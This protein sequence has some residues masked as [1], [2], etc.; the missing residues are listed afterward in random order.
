VQQKEAGSNSIG[1]PLTLGLW[2]TELLLVRDVGGL[3]R[4]RNAQKL[5]LTAKA[6]SSEQSIAAT[7]Q[8]VKLS[9]TNRQEA[10]RQKQRQQVRQN[11][12]EKS[13]DINWKSA[14]ITPG[15]P[16]KN[17]TSMN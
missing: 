10:H 1:G 15:K 17:N 16:S 14:D 9:V 13:T 5:F 7:A 6:R 2:R 4:R 11:E 12:A 3:A 8:D